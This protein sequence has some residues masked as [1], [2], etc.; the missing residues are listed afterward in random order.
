MWPASS[1][2]MQS[3][4]AGVQGTVCGV[5]Y[6][7]PFQ[8]DQETVPVENPL[9]SSKPATSPFGP[10]ARATQ[11]G[12]TQLQPRGTQHLPHRATQAPRGTQLV[13]G[14]A[15][16]VGGLDE[17]EDEEAQGGWQSVPIF[18]AFWQGRLIPGARIDTLPFLE[19]V[20][21]KRN[22]QAKASLLTLA[23]GSWPAGCSCVPVCAMNAAADRLTHPMPACPAPTGHDP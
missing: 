16:A 12:P 7:F 23:E 13:G 10:G 1:L 15:A 4:G 21:S 3:F 2:C 20:R 5:L 8:N 14:A 17:E 11:L 22:A 9:T 18:E 19:A 6:Y